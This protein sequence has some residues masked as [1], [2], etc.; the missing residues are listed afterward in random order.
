M[1]NNETV[2]YIFHEASQARLERVIKR[3]CGNYEKYHTNYHTI[4]KKFAQ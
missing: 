2:P 1:N 4:F 3:L